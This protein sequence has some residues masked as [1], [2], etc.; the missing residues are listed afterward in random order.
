[1]TLTTAQLPLHLLSPPASGSGPGGVLWVGFSGGLDSTVLLHWLLQQKPQWPVRAIYVN[2]G[3]SGNADLWQRHCQQFCRALKVTLEVAPVVLDPAASNLESLAREARFNAFAQRLGPNDVL[4]LAHHQDD[5]A[6]TLLYRLLRGAGVRG[7]G[8]MAPGRKLG[9][10][11]LYRPLLR[12]NRAELEAYAQ[13]HGLNWVEDESNTDVRFDRNYLRQRVL[14]VLRQRW[15]AAAKSLADSAELSRHSDELLREYAAT[16]LAGLAERPEPL[17]FSLP[18]APLAAMTGPRRY[19]ILR[20]WL[21]LRFTQLPSRNALAEIDGQLLTE[22]GRANA[23]VVSGA[24]SVQRFG[25][26]LYALARHQLWQPE[27]QQAVVIWHNTTAPLVLPGGDRLSLQPASGAGIAQQWLQG[28]LS[29]AWRRGGERC[30][31]VG[32]K[33]SQTLKKLLQEQQVPN[34]LRA[35]VPLLYIDGELAAVADYWV[36]QRFA[37]APDAQGWVCHWHW[38]EA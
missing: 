8:A 7:M 35:R 4:L 33:H 37:A 12:V 15:P 21:E 20:Y 19:N 25:P 26:R 36:C 30:Q 18:L 14:P 2:H 3:L 5:Q 11:S 17:G 23:E 29:V 24:V 1:M 32:R 34:W 16:E 22:P 6:E 13:R 38:P 27:P 9:A 28:E 31:P 10:G